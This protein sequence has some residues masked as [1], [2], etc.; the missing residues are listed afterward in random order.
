MILG[1]SV[2]RLDAYEKVT[3]RAKY[4]A[5]LIDERGCLVAKILHATIANGLVTSIDTAA[6]VALPGVE[7][8]RTCF[9]VPDLPFPTAGHPWSTDPAHQD[10]ADRHLLTRRVRLYGDDIAVVIAVDELTATRA[11]RLI[12]VEYEEYPHVLDTES[13]LMAGCHEVKVVCPVCK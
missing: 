10:P 12:K 4:T 7:C 3:G 6:A 2:P 5:D 11:L 9:D 13:S 1:T 8:V